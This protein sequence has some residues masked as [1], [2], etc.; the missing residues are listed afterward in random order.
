MLLTTSNDYAILIGH[1]VIV[2]DGSKACLLYDNTA[3]G[4]NLLAVSLVAK[5]LSAAFYGLAIWASKRSPI[6]DDMPPPS[7][8][9]KQAKILEPAS[10]ET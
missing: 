7:S 5:I 1:N 3:M 2:S 10:Q 6:K 9:K 4:R 8:K